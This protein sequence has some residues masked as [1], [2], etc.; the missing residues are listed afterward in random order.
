VE[1]GCDARAVR[2]A[3]GAADLAVTPGNR[4]RYE[5]L[6]DHQWLHR[7]YRQDGVVALA[8]ICRVSAAEPSSVVRLLKHERHQ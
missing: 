7:R 4:S 5:Q 3:L 8:A 2:R 1:L 6:R